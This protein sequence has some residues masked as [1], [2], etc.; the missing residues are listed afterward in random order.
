MR[1]RHLFA[2]CA[3]QTNTAKKWCF[4]SDNTSGM[5]PAVLEAIS[6]ANEVPHSASYGECNVS[7]LAAD[8]TREALGV[9][10]SDAIVR[11]VSSG[12]SGNVLGLSLAVPRPYN[13]AII[14]RSSHLATNTCGTIERIIG[15]KTILSEHDKLTA[16]E[17]TNIVAT[18]NVA[19]DFCTSPAV[20]SLTLA[21][22]Y[23]EVYSMQELKAIRHAADKCSLKIHIDGARLANACVALADNSTSPGEILKEIGALADVITLGGAKNGLG[24]AEA[25]VLK[26]GV[27]ADEMDVR[28]ASKQLGFVVSKARYVGA[29]YVAY[30]EDDLWVRN[31]THANAQASRLYDLVA[32]KV[33]SV[34]RPVTNQLFIDMTPAQ[35]DKVSEVFE[36]YSWGECIDGVVPVRV[37]TSWC[38]TDEEMEGLVSLL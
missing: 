4:A 30:W 38:T 37:V 8:M 35:L 3:K 20:V 31:A 2:E 23:G 19:R 6:L 26:K 1:L 11:F 27:V 34:V 33:R 9:S 18:C 32:P 22:E 25:V 5:H 36:V 24:T 17:V 28:A 14:S 10:S 16:E 7:N 29:Q 15:C 21:T 13:S 12:T